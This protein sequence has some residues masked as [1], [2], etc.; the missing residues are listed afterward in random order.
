MYKIN[1][2]TQDLDT[3]TFG[4]RTFSKRAKAKEGVPL[5]V[6]A[7]AQNKARDFL[8]QQIHKSKLNAISKELSPHCQGPHGNLS[9]FCSH[10]DERCFLSKMLFRQ[11]GSQKK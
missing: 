8:K 9:F 4:R 7:I 10:F 11:F 1:S 5:F 2:S 6:N 3:I